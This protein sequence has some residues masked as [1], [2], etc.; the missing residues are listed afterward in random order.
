M[1]SSSNF[2]LEASITALLFLKIYT[3]FYELHKLHRAFLSG[4][5][6]PHRDFTR[7]QSK[8]EQSFAGGSTAYSI[9]QTVDGPMAIFYWL[10]SDGKISTQPFT[11]AVWQYFRRF[12][13]LSADGC[14][15]LVAVHGS[16]KSELSPEL[17]ELV[18]CP[19]TALQKW[20]SGSAIR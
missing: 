12:R 11:H 6:L 7:Q 8:G 15:V 1:S 2:S 18:N 10:Q 13:G 20:F 17:V 3:I 4:N 14:F 16:R 5:H 9:I 19:R